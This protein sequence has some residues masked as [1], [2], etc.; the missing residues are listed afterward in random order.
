M[1][2]PEYPSAESLLAHAREVLRLAED[3][4]GGGVL[5]SAAGAVRCLGLALEPWQG[6]GAWAASERLDAVFLHRPWGWDASGLPEEVGVWAL[7]RSF[8]VALT[9]GP[10]RVLAETLGLSSLE[11]LGERRGQPLGM[12]GQ[13]RPRSSAA[14]A[15]LA[16]RVFGGTEDL[17]LSNE[18]PIGR[19]ALMGAM[20]DALVRGAA[21]RGAGLY[22]TGQ[23]REPAKQAVQDTGMSVVAV[24]HRRSELWGIRTL[25]GIVQERWPVLQ[26]AL[27][28]EP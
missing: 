11:P 18:S 15:R 16:R 10:S 13:A 25:A 1:I 22:L 21:A 17:V 20:T 28:P 4:D 14:W 8:D 5:R 9:P 7:H 6:M 3:D 26:I 27:A 2:E 19:V 23:F 12:V 24:G